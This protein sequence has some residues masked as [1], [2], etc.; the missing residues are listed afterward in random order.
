M[1]ASFALPRPCQSRSACWLR[2]ALVL[3]A[4]ASAT[5]AATPPDFGPNVLIFGPTTPSLQARLDVVFAQQERNQFGDE[6]IAL[7]FKPGVYTADVKV[8]FYTHVAGLGRVPDEVQITGAVRSTARW[9]RNNN[10]TCNFWRCAE[11]LAV[12]PTQDRGVNLWAVSQ[13]TSWRRMHVRGDVVLSDG[14]WSS[15]GFIADSKI[16]GQIDSGTQQQWLSRNAE[17]RQWQGGSWNM[18]FVGVNAPPAGEWPAAPYTTVPRTPIV[19]E[20]PFLFVDAQDRYFVQVPALTS[21]T[22]GT[23]WRHGAESGRTIP[24]D[25]FYLAHP[26]RDTAASLN[27]ALQA[28]KHLLFT[29]GIYHLDRPLEITR[30]QTVVLGLGYPTLIAE[31]G[32][33]A[34]SVA[35]VAG[36][37]LAG[38]LLEAGQQASPTLLQVGQAGAPQPGPDDPI[39]IYDLYCRAGGARPGKTACFVTIDCDH[40]IADNLWLWRADHG[41]GAAWTVNENAHG[42]IVNGN[43]VTVYGLFVEH[44]QHYQTLWKGE[45]GRVYFYQSEMPY[46]PPAQTAWSHDGVDGFASYKVAANVRTHEAW[47]LGVYCV[48]VAAPV[49]A[50]SAIEAPERPDVKFHHMVILRL[51]GKP[52]SGI[53]HVLNDRGAPV[54]HDKVSRLE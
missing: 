41:N 7:L 27:Q 40:V 23:T 4:S 48:F 49:I 34:L 10:A 33:S 44:T 42:L 45:R 28:G 2:Y 26:E 14:G 1:L 38:L 20:K 37:R 9:M 24:L 52:E 17:W 22:T 19:A 12:T 47:G 8:G 3:L 39:C 46:D 15:G 54:I 5:L 53:R 6:R 30:P 35:N 43:D 50:A 31:R 25:D 21:N 18:V 11:N 32:T 36:V 51:N 29:P 13:G 16:D